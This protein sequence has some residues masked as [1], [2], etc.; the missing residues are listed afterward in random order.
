MRRQAHTV[1][2]VG[3]ASTATHPTMNTIGSNALGRRPPCGPANTITR[4]NAATAVSTNVTTKTTAK[5][6]ALTP[7]AWMPDQRLAGACLFAQINMAMPAMIMGS[8]SHW[9]MERFIASSPRKSSGCRPNSAMK[10][11]AP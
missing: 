5:M 7:A 11:K 4:T 9:P 2:A 10:R 3:I 6:S 8:E 1:V